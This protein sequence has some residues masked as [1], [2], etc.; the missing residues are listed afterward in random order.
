MKIY[1]HYIAASDKEKFITS[2]VLF[3]DKIEITVDVF[4]D[5]SIA[6]S[7]SIEFSRFPGTEK[8]RLDVLDLLENKYHFEVI[9]SLHE[10]KRQKGYVS[11]RDDSCSVYFDTYFN[12]ANA[13]DA[14]VRLGKKDIKLPENAKVYC[15]I[16]IR[17]SDHDLANL[18][19]IDTKK[20]LKEN[21]TKYISDRNDIKLV[22]EDEN[23]Y[24]SEREMQLYYNRALEELQEELDWRISRWVKRLDM[25]I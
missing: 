21:A 3:D 19:D 12:I 11:N 10:G 1:K 15:F 6:S 13:K 4:P 23:L 17:F 24:V 20:W 8:F 9:E 14:L 22:V 5:Y 7:T 16:H 18:G 2:Q 25:Y